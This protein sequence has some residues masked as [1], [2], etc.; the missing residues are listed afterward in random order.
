MNPKTWMVYRWEV[1]Y[2]L[3]YS[4]AKT[5]YF[6]QMYEFKLFKTQIIYNRY[7]NEK[8]SYFISHSREP[9]KSGFKSLRNHQLYKLRPSLLMGDTNKSPPMTKPL[10]DQSHLLFV[11][12]NARMNRWSNMEIWCTVPG[13]KKGRKPVYFS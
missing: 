4:H 11:K 12:N 3:N 13:K 1:N 8:G 6:I 2:M 7:I 5:Y 10:V 9:L